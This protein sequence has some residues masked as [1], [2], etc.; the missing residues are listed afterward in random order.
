M[1]VSETDCVMFKICRDRPRVSQTNGE[2]KSQQSM[3]I[4]RAEEEEKEE[5]RRHKRARRLVP[6][7]FPLSHGAQMKTDFKGEDE[8]KRRSLLK[9]E[10]FTMGPWANT[11]VLSEKLLWSLQTASSFRCAPHAAT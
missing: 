7:V 11:V 5:K 4:T 8:K 10:C 3:I 1:C 2:D 6:P 9:A